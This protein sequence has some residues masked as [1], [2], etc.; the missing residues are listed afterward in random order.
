MKSISLHSQTL[1]TAMLSQLQ[2]LMIFTSHIFMFLALK[3][4][5][6][7]LA[8]QLTCPVHILKVYNP[9]CVSCMC[10]EVY[11]NQGY[12][13]AQQILIT[14]G[15]TNTKL[16]LYKTERTLL[17]AS[18]PPSPR[19]PSLPRCSKGPL[20]SIRCSIGCSLAYS[21]IGHDSGGELSLGLLETGIGLPVQTVD[22]E[23]GRAEH[24]DT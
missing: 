17:S 18:P 21:L 12:Y 5:I 10:P 8:I 11:V 14:C 3:M 13:I 15:K 1:G 19:R 6:S 9:T 4:L 7:G 22:L 2:H 23:Q 24:T 20:G 16:I